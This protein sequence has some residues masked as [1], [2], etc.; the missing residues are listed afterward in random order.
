MYVIK[1]KHLLYFL[2]FFSIAVVLVARVHAETFSSGDRQNTLIE[3]YTSEGCSS[4]PPAEKYLNSFKDNPDLW[5]TFIPIALHVDYWD[6]L[7]WK[8]RYASPAHTLRQRQ[9]A[10]VNLQDTIYTPGF[11]VNGDPWRRDFFSSS[12]AASKEQTGK[13]SVS[14]NKNRI[15]A[16]FVPIPGGN[17][18]LTLT[19]AILGMGLK[20]SI[21]AGEN[22]GHTSIHE[23]VNLKYVT[24]NS[25]NYSWSFEFPAFDRMQA[26]KLA[27]VAWVSKAGDPRPIQSVGGYIKR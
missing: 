10:R 5:G 12:P 8:D 24:K 4:C 13:L 20:T 17:Q 23:F 9:Y 11:F 2:V 3:L 22:S 1:I 18:P 6:Y 27:L 25:K 7:G 19:V 26:T 16:T 14:L 21:K 15:N